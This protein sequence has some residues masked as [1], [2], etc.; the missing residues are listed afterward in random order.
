MAAFI[1][2]LML[3]LSMTGNRPSYDVYSVII[4]LSMLGLGLF[5]MVQLMSRPN[6]D[7]LEI[8]LPLTALFILHYPLRALFIIIWP[9]LARFPLNWP[10]RDDFYIFQGLLISFAELLF[11]YAGYILKPKDGFQNKR[12][13]HPEIKIPFQHR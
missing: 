6:S 7:L 2:G 1:V 8:V 11:F 5:L 10:V 12:S 13:D 3:Y 9:K 4:G